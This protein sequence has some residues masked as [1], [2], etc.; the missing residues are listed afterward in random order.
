MPGCTRCNL[1]KYSCL[2][3]LGSRAHV[4]HTSPTAGV[5]AQRE[6]A[7]AALL[8]LAVVGFHHG[9]GVERGGRPVS[10]HRRHR[11]ELSPGTD[12]QRGG[13]G[14]APSLPTRTAA[15]PTPPATERTPPPF[16]T[17]QL[18]HG[19]RRATRSVHK[20]SLCGA[21][22]T[23]A[24]HRRAVTVC[25]CLRRSLCPG[26]RTAPVRPGLPR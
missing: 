18:V 7:E 2:G 6:A 14:T 19:E 23:G 4:R 1:S 15:P 10:G 26:V 11:A 3:A 20:A 16:L 9:L 25:H 22:V 5:E 17:A 12:R 24:V 8:P 13:T 21:H